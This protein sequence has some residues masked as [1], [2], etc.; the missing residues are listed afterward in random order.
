MTSN[1]ALRNQANVISRA[2][3]EIEKRGLFKG[4]I[5]DMDADPAIARVCVLGA[6][7]VAVVGCPARMCSDDVLI[8]LY[9]DSAHQVST[10]VG[11]ISLWSDRVS[12]TDLVVVARLREIAAKVFPIPAPPLDN[13]KIP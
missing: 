7:R 13:D 6:L 10:H 5:Y 2:A 1:Q 11:Q 4:Y 3:D 9:V 8:Q 12:S